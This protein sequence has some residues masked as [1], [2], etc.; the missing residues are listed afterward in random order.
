[1]ISLV[2]ILVSGCHVRGM[3]VVLLAAT[4]KVLHSTYPASPIV[5]SASFGNVQTTVEEAKPQLCVQ[6]NTWFDG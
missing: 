2:S 5:V 4:D 1:M 3:Y 6:R